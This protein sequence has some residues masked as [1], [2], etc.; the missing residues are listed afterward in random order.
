MVLVDAGIQQSDWSSLSTS[1]C[2]QPLARTHAFDTITNNAKN[3]QH[4]TWGIIYLDN[5]R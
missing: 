3:A 4:K 5:R 2:K 1:V